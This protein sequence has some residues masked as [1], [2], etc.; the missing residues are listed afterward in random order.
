MTTTTLYLNDLRDY[1]RYLNPVSRLGE[2]LQCLPVAEAEVVLKKKTEGLLIR[3][4]ASKLLQ[5]YAISLQTQIPLRNVVISVNEHKKPIHELVSFNTSH[6]GDFLIV[7][8]SS[9]GHVGID[10]TSCKDEDDDFLAMILGAGELEMVKRARPVLLFPFYW[11]I[12]EAF[13]KYKGEG[14]SRIDDLTK[15][16]V[17]LTINSEP[18]QLDL[19]INHKSSSSSSSNSDSNISNMITWIRCSVAIFVSHEQQPVHVQLFSINQSLVG[20]VVSDWPTTSTVIMPQV[21]DVMNLSLT[22]IP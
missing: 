5:R 17:E 14:L 4:L 15:L 22:Q 1:E 7:A 3:A 20:A 19:A 12:K 8:V 9:E 11:A 21:S 6:E 2:I 18:T 13:L 16:R 10:I